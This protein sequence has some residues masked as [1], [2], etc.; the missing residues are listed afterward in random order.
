MGSKARSVGAE[1]E[2]SET[3]RAGST[4]MAVCYDM[5]HADDV[6]RECGE[7][8]PTLQSRMGTGGNQVPICLDNELA[9]HLTQDPIAGDKS[10]CLSS[11]NPVGGQASVGVLYSDRKSVV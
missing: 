8:S 6:I 5:T 3:L 4:G 11:G 9:F 1:V 7:K 2:R 10:P